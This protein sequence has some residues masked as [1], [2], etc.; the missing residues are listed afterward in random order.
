MKTLSQE[1]VVCL[2]G[3]GFCPPRLLPDG[4]VLLLCD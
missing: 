2:P 4:L 3:I 1:L